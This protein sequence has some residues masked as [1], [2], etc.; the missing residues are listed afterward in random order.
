MLDALFMLLQ[1]TSNALGILLAVN[2]PLTD[3]TSIQL[4]WIIVMLFILYIFIK[5]LQRYLGDSNNLNGK[6]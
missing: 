1:Q 5:A 3:Q 6:S 2:I 4:Y